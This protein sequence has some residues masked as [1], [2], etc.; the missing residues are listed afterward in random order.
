[1]VYDG[2]LNVRELGLDLWEGL[3]HLQAL[4]VI[5]YGS[6]GYTCTGATGMTLPAAS[7]PP[8]SRA[9]CWEHAIPGQLGPA[10]AGRPIRILGVG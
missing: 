4:Q 5:E 2:A 1:M 3:G 10:A 9:S 6:R 7:T 8:Y